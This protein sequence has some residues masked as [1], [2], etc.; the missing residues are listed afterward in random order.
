MLT[1]RHPVAD[2]FVLMCKTAILA[3][4]SARWRW[5]WSQREI[6]PGDEM[7]GMQDPEFQ[8]LVRDIYEFQWVHETLQSHAEPAER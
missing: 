8:K 5:Q 7:S 1:N 4:R 3:M 6:S 2:P